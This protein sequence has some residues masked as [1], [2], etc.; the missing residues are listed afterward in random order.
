MIVNFK[1]DSRI[2]GLV[3][4]TNTDFTNCQGCKNYNICT[5]LPIN[6]IICIY[7]KPPYEKIESDNHS[8][9]LEEDSKIKAFFK[10]LLTYYKYKNTFHNA[11]TNEYL[12][13]IQKHASGESTPTTLAISYCGLS[14]S[15]NDPTKESTLELEI[16]RIAIDSIERTGNVIEVQS[17]FSTTDAN[18]NNTTVSNA[19]TPTTTQFSVTSGTNFN[20]GDRISVTLSSLSNKKVQT[21]ITAKSTNLLTVSPALD[22]APVNTDTVNQL[23]SRINLING[24]A[25]LI[26]NSGTSVSISK[27]VT[28]KNSTQTITIQHTI[29]NS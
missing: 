6:K 24:S 12:A 20:V 8:M 5:K 11:I 4:A 10:R 23:I 1:N 2:Q 7:N 21:K 9:E 19:T 26:L 13:N 17:V 3:K 29:T 18:T 22:V 16:G 27:Y 15:Y 25:S 14:T 28:Q